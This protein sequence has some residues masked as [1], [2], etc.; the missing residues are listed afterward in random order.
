M[1]RSWK[2]LSAAR[3]TLRY[4]HSLRDHNFDLVIDLQ[5]LFRS[6]LLTWATRAPI[7]VGSTNAR[8]FG[9]LF[10]THLAPVHTWWQHAIE[11]YLTVAEFLGLGRDPVEFIFPTDDTDRQFVNELLPNQPFAVLLPATN[12]ETKQWPVENF[13]A[14]IE[15][16]RQRFGLESVLAGGP[17]AAKLAPSLPGAINLAGKTSL[18]QLIAVLE[19][20]DLV[21]ANDTGPMHIAA[22]LKRPLVTM[23]GPTSPIQTGP[24]RRMESVVRLDI[25]C[26]PCF[27]RECSH[28]SCL[29][30][31]G[32][33]PV[34]E[35]AAQQMQAP[36]RRL[37]LPQY[38]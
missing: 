28:H 19:R 31:L 3:E 26:S 23:F 24:Y 14:L 8:E 15:P 27:S 20:A 5:G 16:L 32:I 33:E 37:P 21:I 2:S 25:S 34:L 22:A 1:G 35:L 4:F 38:R 18:R 10:C 30:W 12:W 13:A 11:R 29:R 6:G 36:S 7:R 9:G 17:D